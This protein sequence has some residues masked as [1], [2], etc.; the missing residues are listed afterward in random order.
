V[1]SVAW[2]SEIKNT[3]STFF[4]LLA[5]QSYLRFG[6]DCDAAPGK[7][8]ERRAALAY[9][10][11]TF[12]FTAGLFTKTV[13]CTMPVT[14]LVLRTFKRRRWS[15]REVAYLAPFVFVGAAFGLRT[16]SW[17]KYLIGA[18]GPDWQ[19]S[20]IQRM[21]IA[22]R[23]IGFYVGKL[24]WPHPLAFLYPRWTIPPAGLRSVLP[25]AAVS[26]LLALLWAGRRRLTPAPFT[27]FTLFILILGPA[28]GFVNIFPMKFSFVADHFQYAAGIA[29]IA[30][31]A[32]AIDRGL[33][34]VS[35]Y[36]DR[37]KTLVTVV[38]GLGLGTLTWRRAHAYRDAETLWTDTVAKNPGCMV[39]QVNLG[40][41][42]LERGDV[43]QARPHLVEGLRLKPND[44]TSL[45]A[46]ADLTL[47]YDKDPDGAMLYLRRALDTAEAVESSRDRMEMTMYI[48]T[49]MAGAD[50]MAH[51]DADALDQYQLALRD[52]Q[53]MKK[54][55][56]F[57][58]TTEA[59]LALEI[60]CRG[61]IGELLVE[62]GKPRDA[63]PYL[64]EAM[65]LA[66]KQADLAAQYGVALEAV[67]QNARAMEEY[68]RSLKLDANTWLARLRLADLLRRS[69]RIDDAIAQYR[70]IVEFNPDYQAARNTLAQLLMGENRRAEAVQ[71]YQAGIN[72]HAK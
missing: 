34:R 50:R 48:H 4:Y 71:V 66:P 45:L 61:A 32:A 24:L 1:E 3:Q 55:P 18:L 59:L 13:V 30:L 31:A 6:E 44:V 42:L 29:L 36:P 62:K 38:L 8:P 33:D 19:L 21:N 40:E 46:M 11:S 52:V 2:I 64:E 60:E 68:E 12:F 10:L 7:R 72:L 25:S 67:G 54:Q 26:G 17:E 14:A 9:G 5:L 43:A 53:E 35:T 37:W 69:G 15:W 22:G 49:F 23:A 41:R 65:R 57:D 56:Y 39:A 51:R 20:F 47:N 27:A 58:A 70:T 16:A 28:L 63:I